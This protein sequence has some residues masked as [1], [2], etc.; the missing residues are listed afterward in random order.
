VNHGETIW[1]GQKVLVTGGSSFIGSHLVDQLVERG[2][3]VRVVDDLSSGRLENI[4]RHLANGHAEFLEADLR[5][6]GVARNAMQ[7]IDTVFHLAADP[8]DPAA[9]AEA[10]RALSRD[11]QR[12]AEMGR[13]ARE[14]AP[15]YDRVKQLEIFMHVIEEA[16]L[17]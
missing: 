2:A 6:P 3:R 10:V 7:G 15:G 8:D 12:V 17:K 4:R 16:A 11:P 14:I 5:E 1:S 13:R 9:L